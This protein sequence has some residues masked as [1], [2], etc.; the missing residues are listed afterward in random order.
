MS[1]SPFESEFLY[2]LHDPG[3]EHI[4]R[5]GDCRGWVLFSE[6]IRAGPAD[7]GGSHH[8]Y[9]ALSGDGFGVIV[10]L[11]HGYYG[12]GTLPHS[13][14]YENFARRCANFVG[15]SPGAHMW[16]IGNE[17]NMAAERPGAQIDWSRGVAAPRGAVPSPREMRRLLSVTEPVARRGAVIVD[18]GEVITPEL[19]QRCYALC[20]DAIRNLAGHQ[21]DLILIGSVAP[22]NDNSGDWI[23]YFREILTRLGPGGCDGITVH[24]Y[25]H[26]VSPELIRDEGKMNPPHDQ[27]HFNFRTYQDFM[28]AIPENMRHLPVYITETDQDA[29]W[30]NRSDST[31]VRQAYGELDWWNQQPGNQQIRAM[32]LYRWQNHDHWVIEGKDGVIGDFKQAQQH[33]YRWKTD[34]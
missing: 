21:D 12:P 14:E 11:N 30:D 9:A 17:M 34:A 22:W 2:G 4:M 33:K 25:T 3:G 29:A 23:E 10:R 28:Q 18:P 32:V 6:E 1:K 16:I 20:R 24:T 5:E 8:N 19:Y 7:Q 27:Y 26:G 15:H 31:W 13:S